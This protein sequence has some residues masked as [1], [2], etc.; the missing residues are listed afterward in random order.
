MSSPHIFSGWPKPRSGLCSLTSLTRPMNFKK[1]SKVIFCNKAGLGF[2]ARLC[3]S[4]SV[5]M[6]G[7]FGKLCLSCWV[8]CRELL[9][10]LLVRCSL[11]PLQPMICQRGKTARQRSSLQGGVCLPPTSTVSSVTFHHPQPVTGL[12]REQSWGRIRKLFLLKKSTANL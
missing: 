8:I 2:P 12:R 11:V 5:M 7:W 1:S 10:V 4:V 6:D 9:S 3:H